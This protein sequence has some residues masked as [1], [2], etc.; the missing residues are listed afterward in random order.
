M[1]CLVIAAGS[2]L[3]E[4]RDTRHRET[5]S[6]VSVKCLIFLFLKKMVN[7]RPLRDWERKYDRLYR[8][9]KY[10]TAAYRGVSKALQAS[11]YASAAYAAGKLGY[12]LGQQLVNSFSQKENGEMAPTPRRR[13]NR[14]NRT[15]S[16]KSPTPG[17]RRGRQR[18]QSVPQTPRKRSTSLMVVDSP[19]GMYIRGQLKKRR[20]AQYSKSAG[21]FKKGTKKLQTL[22][23]FAKSGAVYALEQGGVIEDSAAPFA[24]SVIIGHA[25]YTQYVLRAIVAYAMSKMV[26]KVLLVD[27][28]AFSEPIM[29]PG[30]EM[31]IKIVYRQST[32]GAMNTYSIAPTSW[33]TLARGIYDWFKQQGD[34]LEP[35]SME[36]L[37]RTGSTG[38]Y[39]KR[40]NLNLSKC[41]ID[42][43]AKSALKIQNRTV[44]LTANNDEE[45]VDNVPLYGKSYNG[46]GNF[47]CFNFNQGT[48]Q[49]IA[50]NTVTAVPGPFET[51]ASYKYPV[52]TLKNTAGSTLAEP[53]GKA[54]FARVNA[55]GK[56]HLDPGQIKTDVL[57]YRK[58]VTLRHFIQKMLNY[59]PNDDVSV[60]GGKFRF[61]IF[62]KMIQAQST[63][64]QKCIRIAYEQDL[65][66]AAS[67]TAPR[68]VATNYVVDQTPV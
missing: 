45:D 48:L 35:L 5:R 15:L 54:Q 23:Q 18:T 39:Q 43:Y 60:S 38:A 67:A 41:K 66:L 4:R 22:D 1:S 59:L 25:S 55:V 42:L 56:A 17:P 6:S 49:V 34:S 53:P 9:D 50:P 36:C 16:P 2:Y 64:A 63:D 26:A 33:E 12:G 65:K 62:E 29:E 28:E 31:L 21:F 7:G 32:Y 3:L 47:A 61:F 19:G 44:N 11:K 30:T 10:G 40:F 58:Q 51:V 37:T 24:Q 46:N 27:F 68:S 20:G 8:I 14:S 13:S 57:I 52:I